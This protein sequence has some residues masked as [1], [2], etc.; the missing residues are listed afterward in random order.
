MAILRFVA[1]RLLI[2]FFAF[3]KSLISP[4]SPIPFLQPRGNLRFVTFDT[5]AHNA[6]QRV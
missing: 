1:L 6:L 2:F 3:F 4:P 5:Y